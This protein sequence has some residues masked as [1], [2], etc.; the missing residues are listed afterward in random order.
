LWPKD[1]YIKV[2][3]L[4]FEFF[5]IVDGNLLKN[6]KYSELR[7]NLLRNYH[8]FVYAIYLNYRVNLKESIRK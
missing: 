1:N 6:K 4:I 7:L 2:P 8:D 3:I 5:L